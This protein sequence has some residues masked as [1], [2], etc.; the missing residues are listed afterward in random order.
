MA[1][2]P[3]E[4]SIQSIPREECIGNSLSRINDNFFNLRTQT[5]SNYSELE[6]IKSQIQLF[7][8]LLDSISAAAIPGTSKAWLKFDGTRGTNGQV[9]N[10]LTNRYIYS[11]YNI[12]SVYKKAVGDYRIYF[13]TPFPNSNYVVTGT[14]SQTKHLNDNKYT[15]LQPYRYTSTFLDVRVHGSEDETKTVDPE[16][17]SI[18]FF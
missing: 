1:D 6:S 13:T 9:T 14:S 2:C 15:W 10:L 8:T 3:I 4:N 7:Q 5:C 16:H 11:S 12:E 17:V 18:N